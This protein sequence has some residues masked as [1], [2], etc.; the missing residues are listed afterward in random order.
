MSYYELLGVSASSSDSEIKSA[1]RKLAM[2]YH[3]DRNKD[4]PEAEQKFKEINHAY[5]VLKDPQK[6]AAYD[7]VGHDAFERGMA[8]GSAGGAGGFGGGFGAFSDIFEDMF[9]DVM[10]ARGGGRGRGGTMRGSDIQYTTEITL[11]EA[12]KGVEKTLTFP[13]AEEC[14]RCSGDGAE[15]GTRP[16]NCPTCNGAGRMRMQQ[17]PFVIE[18]TCNTCGGQGNVLRSPCGACAGQGRVQGEKKLKVTIPAGIDTGRRIRLSGEGEAGVKGGAKGDL[19]VLVVVKPHKFFKRD[20]AN[21][22]TR[23]PIPM[24]TAALGGS[25]DVPTIEGEKLSID[26]P[27]GTQSGQ[28]IRAKGKGMSVVRSQTRGDMFVEIAVETPVN[29]DKKQKDLMKQLDESLG[30]S[31]GKHSPES[32]GFF[33]KVKELWE[34]LTE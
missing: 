10:G 18:R 34:D 26:I 33:S 17:G 7:R 15:P 30:G 23:V 29:L 12:F 32:S 27:V 9:G 4:N 1:Y 28:E 31:A 21:L 13:V 24:T 20:D 16:E 22:H 14:Q 19:Y 2:K 3:P 25:I 6:R 8:G 5:D 11:E